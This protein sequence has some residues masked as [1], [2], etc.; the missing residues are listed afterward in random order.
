VNSITVAIYNKGDKT[1]CR[2]YTNISV[3]STTYKILSNI[4]LSRLTLY[5]EEII[6]I[7]YD[8]FEG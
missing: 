7:E 4:L 1:D 5:A 2:K 8:Y 3:L 6:S